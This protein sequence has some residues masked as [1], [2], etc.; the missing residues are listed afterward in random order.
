MSKF[1]GL[2]ARKTSP[3]ETLA[4]PDPV[5]S[6]PAAT[7]TPTTTTTAAPNPTT[8]AKPAGTQLQ[9]P[10]LE[11]DEEL[12]SALGSQLGGE[13]EALR[14]L[15]LDA[16]HKISELDTIK[17]S[18]SKLVD[19]VT[20]ALSAFEAEKSEKISLQTVLNNTRTAYGRLRNEIS[21]LEKKAD[22]FEQEALQLRQELAAAVAT[23]RGVESAKSELAIDLQAKR[24]QVTD[25]EFTLQQEVAST[26][27]FAEEN[28][29]LNERLATADKR[30]TQV[31]ADLHGARQKLA[32]VEDERRAVQISLDK[33][34]GDS[35]RLSRR[36]AEAEANH[37]AVQGRLR[38]VES[39]LAE[40]TSERARLASSIE[41]INERHQ[42]ELA[43]QRMRFETLQARSAA[44]DKLLAEAR[45]HLMSRAED[46]RAMERRVNEM[47]LERDNAE[48]RRA[49]AEAA[50]LVRENEIKDL[51]LERTALQERGSTLAKALTARDNGLARA[52]EKL[53]LLVDR[54]TLL[55]SEMETARQLAE[56]ER[57]ALTAAVK[58][59]KL[60]RALTEGALETARKDFSRLMREVLTLQRR[61]TEL[62]GG[63]DPDM[64]AA[65]AA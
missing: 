2:L 26:K 30:S 44:S 25:L 34:I 32:L 57:D 11:V 53:Q 35:A 23:L 46:L 64:L 1:G 49:E 59:E 4:S 21:G 7:P 52:E 42:G 10:Y 61:Q 56:N 40:I 6:Q 62:D 8:T 20:K 27:K 24:A 13:N 65:N 63:G 58:R 22:S 3:V 14:N 55:E 9:S 29:R 60:E 48:A 51:Q 50:R 16:N 28:R 43:T 36:L 19:P 5:A 18:V 41:E 37:S 54:I 47:A 45:D 17:E 38:H 39:N 31:E 33:Q 15:L 12:F